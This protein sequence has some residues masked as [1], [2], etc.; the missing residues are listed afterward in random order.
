MKFTF[1]IIIGVIVGTIAITVLAVLIIFANIPSINSTATPAASA[2]V[3]PTPR[4]SSVIP[5]TRP[6]TFSSPAS[7]SPAAPGLSIPVNVNFSLNIIGISGSGLTRTVTGEISNTGTSDAHNAWMKIEVSTGGKNI[8][9]NGQDFIRKDLGT[10]K[11]KTSITDQINMTFSLI[12][13][14]ALMNNGATVTMTIYSDEK[15]QTMTYDYK[16]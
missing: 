9:I 1:G 11:A 14:P 6:P 15:T 2:T 3:T 10:I 5:S 8:R 16:P 13:G 12:D 7:S 4:I